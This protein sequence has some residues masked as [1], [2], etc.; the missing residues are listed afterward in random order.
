MTRALVVG[1]IYQGKYVAFDPEK[2]KEIIAFG[3]DVGEVVNIAREKGV[4]DPAVVFVPKD[5]VAYVY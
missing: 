1:Q 4:V 2:G 3:E 5:D